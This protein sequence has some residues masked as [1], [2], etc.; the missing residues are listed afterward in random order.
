MGRVRE[1]A[2]ADLGDVLAGRVES[3]L[4]QVGETFEKPGLEPGGQAEHVA[5]DQHLTVA[6]RPR[7][8]ADG[9]N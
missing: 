1:F 8:D 6:V 4:A 9:W 2:V 5:T 7:A 3:R